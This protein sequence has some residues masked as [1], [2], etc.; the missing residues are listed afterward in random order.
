MDPENLFEELGAILS[1]YEADG[2]ILAGPGFTKRDAH[3]YLK[4]NA[5]G[6][7]K[8]IKVI[9]TAG[10]GGRGVHEV[11]KRGAVETVAEKVRI[12]RESRIVDELMERVSTDGKATYGVEEVSDAAEYGAIENLLIVD[13]FLR[14]NRD[15]LN[16][17]LET[18]EQKGGDVTVFSSE[19]DPGRQLQNLGG[20]AALLRYRL[21]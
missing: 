7:A 21:E 12:A 11:L 5:P 20:V 4:E 6:V 13:E 3:E 1:R 15:E 9:D 2:V 14:K 16:P 8:R 19:F 17:T 10:V 18:V